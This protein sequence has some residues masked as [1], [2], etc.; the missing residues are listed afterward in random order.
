MKKQ[1]NYR[2]GMMIQR[3][4]LIDNTDI[5]VQHG[6]IH[7]ISMSCILARNLKPGLGPPMGSAL[8]WKK[9]HPVFIGAVPGIPGGCTCISILFIF[10][11]RS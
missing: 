2:A 10:F 8:D 9:I 7:M 6:L 1:Y 11:Q 3:L 5:H 4:S